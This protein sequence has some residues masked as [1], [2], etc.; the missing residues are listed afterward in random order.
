[1][2]YHLCLASF[3]NTPVPLFFVP[4]RCVA[5]ATVQSCRVFFCATT[6]VW[7]RSLGFTSV[8]SAHSC[9]NCSLQRFGVSAQVLSC[10]QSFLVSLSLRPIIV[11]WLKSLGSVVLTASLLHAH[12]I[13]AWTP[14]YAYSPPR[15]R[16][17][18]RAQRV[19]N[20]PSGSGAGA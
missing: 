19:T 14:R 12:L 7:Q 10:F 15:S 1:M 11:A 18:A 3:S 2:N 17:T 8:F 16:A 6:A 4:T 9:F 13:A 5:G 20:T